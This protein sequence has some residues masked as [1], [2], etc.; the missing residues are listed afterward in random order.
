MRKVF[1]VLM[2]LALSTVATPHPSTVDIVLFEA[3]CDVVQ[4]Y[5]PGKRTCKYIQPPKILWSEFRDQQTGRLL[6]MGGGHWSYS[7]YI[8]IN[9]R[10]LSWATK[11][12][13]IL[14]ET[15]HYVAFRT[16]GQKGRCFGEEVARRGTAEYFDKEYTRDW[17]K[18]YGC[19]QKDIAS[20]D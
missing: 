1:L 11:D 17:K 13:L 4:K 14:H 16:G 8:M 3:A 12:E 5:Y 15:I 19:E 20:D 7:N 10:P 6:S 18:P 2:L 9:V